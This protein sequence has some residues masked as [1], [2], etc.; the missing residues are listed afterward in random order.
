MPRNP[1]AANANWRYISR[2]DDALKQLIGNI[3]AAQTE[4]RFNVRDY[5]AVGDGVADDSAAFQAAVDAANEFRN[6]DA[7]LPATELFIPS[8]TYRV[9]DIDLDGIYRM[10][11]RGEDSHSAIL[12]LKAGA[13][14]VLD[15]S[16]VGDFSYAERD[17]SLSHL[18]FIA[19][20]DSAVYEFVTINRVSRWYIHDLRFFPGFAP[21]EGSYCLKSED[22]WSGRISDLFFGG[23]SS[24]NTMDGLVLGPWGGDMQ[25]SNIYGSC[26]DG[27]RMENYWLAN[28]NNVQL[29]AVRRYGIRLV[30]GEISVN[31]IWMWAGNNG[32]GQ[33]DPDLKLIWLG[34]GA[35]GCH[36]SNFELFNNNGPDTA[37]NVPILLQGNQITLINGF[38]RGKAQAP[39][40]IDLDGAQRCQVA[41]C[42]VEG[43]ARGIRLNNAIN[44]VING[45]LVKSATGASIEETGTADKNVIGTNRTAGAVTTVGGSTVA[46]NNLAAAM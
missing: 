3:Y 9:S 44:N 17:C 10:A 42:G 1:L 19:E 20:D 40:V 46:A 37:A 41:N 14:R 22:S 18:S 32:S 7:T 6:A 28:I 45:N 12:M 34:S 30:S 21:L 23:L 31:N 26:R 25:L 36:I 8:G 24:W 16:N 13:S 27:I 35:S 29:A 15:L 43:A 4:K 11:I 2:H 5:G 33:A 39:A 38:A